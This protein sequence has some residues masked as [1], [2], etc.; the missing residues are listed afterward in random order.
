MHNRSFNRL[1]SLCSLGPL[2]AG[3]QVG[4]ATPIDTGAED[5]PPAE[6]GVILEP[7]H[8]DVLAGQTDQ[9][10]VE[11]RGVHTQPGQVIEIQIPDAANDLTRWSTLGVA[12]TADDPGEDGE[13]Y[14]WSATVTPGSAWVQGGLLRMRAVD[15]AGAVLARLYHGAGDCFAAVPGDS[16]A[17]E[18]ARCGG[19]NPDTGLILSSPVTDLA[20][21]RSALEFLTSKGIGTPAETAEYY[22]TIA[23]PTTVAAFRARF[24]FDPTSDPVATYYN[25]GDLATG[26][27]V[28][29]RPYAIASGNGVACLTSNYGGFSTD[30]D[31]SIRRAIAGTET[32]VST[33]AFATVAMIYKAPITSPNSVQFVVYGPDGTL[34]NEAGLDT[35]GDNKSIPHNC[36][37]CH[38]SGATYDATTNQVRGARFLPLDP[39]GFQFSDLPGY[40]RADQEENV[41]R[42]NE[43]I[44]T[45]GLTVGQLETIDGMYGAALSVPGTAADVEF[46]PPG[47]SGSAVEQNTYSHAVAPFCRACHTSRESG[48][49]GRDPIDFTTSAGTRPLAQVIGNVVCG[50]PSSGASHAMPNAQAVVRRFWAGPARAYLVDYL[51]LATSCAP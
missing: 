44:Y 39:L 33:G 50:T 14:E 27:E 12:V 32:D 38:G 43:T 30:V 22:A 47:W 11:V 51:G 20:D 29:C 18:I 36:L 46:L 6:L 15:E 25:L 7:R 17:D 19:D 40:T 10:R 41:R 42:L 13:L 37:N 4:D 2:V 1:I 5:E 23:A 9:L 34:A 16:L 48:G 49:G 24:G 45:A 28:R 3:C 21:A 31:D 26:R 35:H 8:G